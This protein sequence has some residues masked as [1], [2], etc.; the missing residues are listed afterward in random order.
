MKP[1]KSR[2]RKYFQNKLG[3]KL[4]YIGTEKYFLKN[5]DLKSRSIRPIERNYGPLMK[6]YAP[7]TED[8]GPVSE[9]TAHKQN[10]WAR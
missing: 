9:N 7:V 8:L 1:N 6:E 4:E 3:L 2:P 10:I 5:L